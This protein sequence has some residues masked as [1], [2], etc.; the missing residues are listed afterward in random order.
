MNKLFT[1]IIK[2]KIKDEILDMILSE[3]KYFADVFL[4]LN[5]GEK[6]VVSPKALEAQLKNKY[7]NAK[8]SLTIADYLRSKG[9]KDSEIFENNN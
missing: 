5:S 7:K 8:S 6:V 1:K 9:F 4:L 2:M 3:A